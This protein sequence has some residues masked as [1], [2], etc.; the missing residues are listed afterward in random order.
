MQPRYLCACVSLIIC[1]FIGS[2]IYSLSFFISS[3]DARFDSRWELRSPLADLSSWTYQNIKPTFS[4][5]LLCLFSEDKPAI[6]RL[7]LI[8]HLFGRYLAVSPVLFVSSLQ[9]LLEF[10]P[11]E[12]CYF[13]ILGPI[14]LKLHILAQLIESFPTAY[15]LRNCIEIKLSIPL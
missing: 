5:R 12:S 9:F 3:L 4:G 10:S 8:S 15:G 11:C 6:P 2:G 7:G 14:L 1:L 13:T